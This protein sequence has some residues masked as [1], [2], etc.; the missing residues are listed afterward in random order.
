MPR[1]LLDTPVEAV[2]SCRTDAWTESLLVNKAS[3]YINSQ[4]IDITFRIGPEIISDI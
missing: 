3:L 1:A 4:V 2:A